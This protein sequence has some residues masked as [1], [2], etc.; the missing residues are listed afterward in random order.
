MMMIVSVWSNLFIFN[1]FQ[2][3]KQRK[4]KR[5]KKTKN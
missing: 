4:R 2:R 1:A 5:I 3:K